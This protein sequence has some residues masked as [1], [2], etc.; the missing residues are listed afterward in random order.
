MT[1]KKRNSID[2]E[3]VWFHCSPDLE[4]QDDRSVVIVLSSI[5]DDGLRNYIETRFRPRDDKKLDKKFNDL[6][7]R[8]Y[9]DL[10]EPEGPLGSFGARRKLAFLLNLIG[11]VTHR[12]LEFINKIRNRFAHGAISI[13]SKQKPM[14]LTFATPEIQSWVKELKYSNP[15]IPPISVRINKAC[16]GHYE[17]REKFIQVSA[18]TIFGLSFES[19]EQQALTKNTLTI[20]P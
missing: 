2:L 11:P 10:L 4:N 8:A 5:I 12:N 6:V 3:T 16:T 18:L 13:D 20:M 1:R 7:S 9:D 15:E 19:I 14:N 17:L